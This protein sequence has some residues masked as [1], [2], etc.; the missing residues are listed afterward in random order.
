MPFGLE[1]AG[2]ETLTAM[3]KVET[4]AEDHPVR[5]FRITSTG[6]EL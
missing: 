1:Q 5:E 2:F 3:E 4:N 6:D